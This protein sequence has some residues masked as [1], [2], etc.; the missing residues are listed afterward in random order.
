MVLEKI[1]GS[2]LDFKETKPVNL[3]GNQCFGRTDA[4]AE[5]PILLPPDGKSQFIGK[6]PDSGQDEGRRRSR[7]QAIRWLD[8]T[9]DSMDMNLCKIQEIVKDRGVWCATVQGVTKEL[10]TT[11]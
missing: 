4:E 8:S 3:K 5:A 6:D 11:Y 2:L 1:P 9:I 7:Q 10:D